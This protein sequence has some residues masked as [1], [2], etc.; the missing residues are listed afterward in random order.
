MSLMEDRLTEFLNTRFVPLPLE[1]AIVS[2][3]SKN[4]ELIYSV[5][6]CAKGK[7]LQEKAEIDRNVN[8][9][10]NHLLRQ[11]VLY[12]LCLNI[13]ECHKNAVKQLIKKYKIQQSIYEEDLI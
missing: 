7:N 13:T 10:C 4:C 8:F 9:F 12:G 2:K 5:R 3:A 6:S 11:D 1:L